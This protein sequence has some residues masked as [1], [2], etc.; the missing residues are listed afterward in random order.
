M[1]IVYGIVIAALCVALLLGVQK[2]RGPVLPALSVEL[3]PRELRIVA[4]GEVR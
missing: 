2:W 1:R 3:M 4:R